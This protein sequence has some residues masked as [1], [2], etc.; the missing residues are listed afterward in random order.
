MSD[1]ELKTVHK[2][3]DRISDLP[4]REALAALKEM[5]A[6]WFGELRPETNAI[7]A[8]R[9]AM[10]RRSLRFVIEQ[11]S[12]FSREAIHMLL[13]A[14]IRNYD[15]KDLF[16]EI[17]ENI[18]EERGKFTKD[19]P[20]LEMMRR[21]YMKD[22]GIDTDN[23]GYCC[24]TTAFIRKMRTIF[25]HNDN[26]FSAGALLAFE[27]H[28]IPEF[29]TIDGIITAYN[30]QLDEKSLTK[31]YINGHKD[32][33][34]EHEAHLLKSIEP[35][36]DETNI[37]KLCLG[38]LTVSLTMD[39]WWKQ[40]AVEVTRIDFESELMVTDVVEFNIESRFEK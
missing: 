36:I 6:E 39:I 2:E 27:G 22:L 31:L 30:E 5:T 32:F 18:N 16:N 4:Y 19:V 23:V 10:H 20:H 12:V 9:L 8:D 26:A 40:L 11:Y 24:A 17:Q 37:K 34:I 35:Y 13:D 29:H 3:I 21:G 15:W 28:A 33:E 7:Y 14:M 1:Q 25:N 38:Y